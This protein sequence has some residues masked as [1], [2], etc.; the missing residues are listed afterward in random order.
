M[1]GPSSR[2]GGK[3]SRVS[4]L[5]EEG[6]EGGE[7]QA[8]AA[9][10]VVAVRIHPK[11]REE[12]FE[13][14]TEDAFDDDDD[15][16]DD[17]GH[18]GDYPCTRTFS[19]D[20]LVGGQKAGSFSA[21]LVDRQRAGSLFHEACDAESQEL[22]E[23]GC[24]LFSSKGAP[25]YPALKSDTSVA[26][27][28]YIY[29]DTFCLNAEHRVD[30]ATDV[31]AAA[32]R[33]LLSLPELA[34]RWTVA[35]YI[36]DSMAVLSAEEKTAEDERQR[37]YFRGAPAETVKEKSSRIAGVHA[38]MAKDARQFLRAGFAEVAHKEGGW[39]YLTARMMRSPPMTHAEALA[40]PLRLT[41]KTTSAGRPELT[42]AD[43]QLLSALTGKG[44]A[45]TATVLAAVDRFVAQ[46]ADLTRAGVLQYCA[47]N[48]M[49]ELLEPMLTRGAQI[50][51]K[52]G[53]TGAT[54]LMVAA[55]TVSAGRSN[56]SQ[57]H[58]TTM[59]STLIALGA[60]K[61]VVDNDGLSAFGHYLK[62]IRNI[63]DFCATFHFGERMQKVDPM[64]RQMLTPVGGPTS[65]DKKYADDH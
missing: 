13:E 55:A 44:G 63:N 2:G 56:H 60:D 31:G 41:S 59:V 53:H 23:F 54:A 10:V 7:V 33:A 21:H 9:N 3:R 46:G 1:G 12:N 6:R 51:G 43:D 40:V 35:S 61:N 45:T 62:G 25:R 57:Q 11:E 48:G 38:R 42:D 49:L 22:Q 15:D 28:G 58:Y 16:D 37:A 20:I 36:A 52:D 5:E 30:G 26:R 29:I 17:L 65:A 19:G 27:G 39:L 64:M 4:G 50:N 8:T 34:G 47:A 32:I 18:Q 24:L 14:G